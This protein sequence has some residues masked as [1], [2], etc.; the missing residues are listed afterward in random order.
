MKN[1]IAFLLV[2]L[3]TIIACKQEKKQENVTPAPELTIL[4]KVAYAHGFE[5]WKNVN[6]IRFT[7]NVER[8]TTHFERIWKW[9][10][11]TNEVTGNSMGQSTTY[12]RKSVDSISARIN[13][14]FINDKFWLL[15]PYQ[16][17]WDA[18]NFTYEHTPI[19][20]APISKTP[21]QKLS[22]VYGAEGGTTPGDAY[23]FYFED[24]YIIK[25]WVFRKGNR[26]E[27]SMTTTFEDYM[28]INRLKIAQS[29]KKD[30]EKF[31]L[32]FTEISVK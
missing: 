23:D 26:T 21:M 7:F 22:I 12:N 11:K 32:H 29:H 18:N 4:Q 9:N 28:D 17:V 6:E 20:N 31:K 14:A 10:T 3:L 13:A 30:G 1:K 8:D 27:A 16:L 25:E 2:L 15:A 5:A 24:D 19:A